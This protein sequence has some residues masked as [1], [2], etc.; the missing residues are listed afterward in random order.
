[1][2]GLWPGVPLATFPKDFGLMSPPDRACTKMIME[3]R[4]KLRKVTNHPA[5]SG[6]PI[7]FL[8]ASVFFVFFSFRSAQS[9]SRPARGHFEEDGSRNVLA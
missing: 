6:G 9:C 4:D 8:F 5:H 3:E 1:M 2:S 7:R